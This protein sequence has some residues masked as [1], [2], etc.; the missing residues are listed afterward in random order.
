MKLS[1][2]ILII[3]AVLVV[4][5]TGTVFA[6]Q[7]TTT[8][9]WYVPSNKS[10]SIAYGSTCSSIA[11][12][13]PEN[14]AAL[15]SDIDG[16]GSGILPYNDRP[17]T[18]ACQGATTPAMT[19]TNN[20][21][22]IEN[23]DANITGIDTNCWVK[24]WKGTGQGA[25]GCGVGELGDG[26]GG[27]Q[28]DCNRTWLTTTAVDKNGC[29]DFNSGNATVATRMITGLIAG[30]ANELCFSGEMRDANHFLFGANIPA[31]ADQNAVFQTSTNVS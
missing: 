31:N 22:V 6:N 13:F 5:F 11:F 30:D 9:T 18:S 15:D 19:V 8:M 16:N 7:L 28:T 29:K 2:K 17:G 25:G 3:Y 1:A 12:F 20:G 14:Q 26:L 23:I 21:N 4:C 10:H 24:V 27:W